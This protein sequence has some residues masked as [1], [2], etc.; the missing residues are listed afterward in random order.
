[1]R[2]TSPPSW[3]I[4]SGHPWLLTPPARTGDSPTS[5]IGVRPVKL[6]PAQRDQIAVDAAARYRAGESWAQ[7]GADYGIT[8]A[9]TYRLT[10]ARHDITFRRW[11]QQLV[12]DAHEE[13]RR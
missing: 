13:T 9:Y 1:S 6:S 3:A 10:T 12:A 4:V 7:I 5:S 11:V 8:G 2:P